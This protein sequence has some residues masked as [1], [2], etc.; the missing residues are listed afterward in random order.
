MKLPAKPD[1]ADGPGADAPPGQPLKIATER[2]LRGNMRQICR[3]LD[4]HPAL[5]RLIFINPI[6]VLE[7]VGVELS[8]QVRDHIMQALRFPPKRRSRIDALRVE[9]RQYCDVRGLAYPP[10]AHDDS[11]SAPAAETSPAAG[12]PTHAIPDDAT[13]AAKLAELARLRQGAL[14]FFPRRTYEQFKSGEKTHRWIKS[15]RFGV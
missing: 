9:I 8:P 3:R 1:G 13:L 6:L 12:T 4:A 14:T 11:A 5:S 10:A 7:D 2:D 15:V